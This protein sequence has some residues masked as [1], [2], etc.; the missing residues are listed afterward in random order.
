MIKNILSVLVF[1]FSILF[2]YFVVNTYFS[3][4]QQTKINKNR[5][6]ILKKIINNTKGLPILLNDTNKVIEFNSDF[7]NENKKKERNFWRLFDR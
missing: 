2:L 5:K 7:K 1:L 3:D 6:T 4:N